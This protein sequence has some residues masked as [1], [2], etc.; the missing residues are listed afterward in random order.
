M[1]AVDAIIDQRR[2][3][4]AFGLLALP[5]NEMGRARIASVKAWQRWLD[6]ATFKAARTAHE[7]MALMDAP[8]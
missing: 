6:T 3:L 2:T 1:Q 7:T 8:Y 4:H 5:V